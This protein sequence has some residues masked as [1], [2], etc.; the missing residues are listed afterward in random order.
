MQPRIWDKKWAHLINEGAVT[1]KKNAA[2]PPSD[3]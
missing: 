3:R 1:Q 2:A